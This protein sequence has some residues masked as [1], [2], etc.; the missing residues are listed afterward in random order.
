MGSRTSPITYAGGSAF[1]WT[2]SADQILAS[3][4][5]QRSAEG[6]TWGAPPPRTPRLPLEGSDESMDLPALLHDAEGRDA[7]ALWDTTAAAVS[8]SVCDAAT[9][10]RT[11]IATVT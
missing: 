1:I 11:E 10:A 3:E 9:T 7:T 4:F 5:E 6:S 2:K 8:V